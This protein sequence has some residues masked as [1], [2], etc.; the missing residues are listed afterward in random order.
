MSNLRR[1]REQFHPCYVV[2]LDIQPSSDPSSC[3]ENTCFPCAV[4]RE[5]LSVFRLRLWDLKID[6]LTVA[7]VGNHSLDFAPLYVMR[8]TRDPFVLP[9]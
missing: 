5:D 1:R 3:S 8:R 4:E 6:V 9:S 7:A 2:S